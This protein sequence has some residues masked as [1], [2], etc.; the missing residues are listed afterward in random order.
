MQS[1]VPA[2]LSS[3]S[4]LSFAIAQQ[5]KVQQQLKQ[6]IN[7]YETILLNAPLGY[8]QVDDENRLMWCNYQA[9]HLLGIDEG[10][11]KPRLLLE[12]VRSYELDELVETTR[13]KGKLCCTDWTFYYVSPDPS[14]LSEQRTCA[15]R[16]YGFPLPDNQVGIFLENRQEAVTLIQRCDRWASDLAHELKTPLTSIRLVAETL[17]SRLDPPLKTWVDRLISETIRLSN[18]VQDLLDLSR[19]QRD[20]FN[21]LRLQTIDL[22]ELVFA[23]WESLEPLA[24]KQ[25]L[26]LDYQGPDE[27]VLELDKARI[28]RL[29]VNL[30]DNAIKHSPA[31]HPIQV[32]ISLKLPDGETEYTKEEQVCLEVIDYGSGFSERDL[33]HVFDRFYRADPS[34]TRHLDGHSPPADRRFDFP[35]VPRVVRVAS[36]SIGE[37]SADFAQLGGSGLGLAIVQQIVEAHRGSVKAA[38]HPKTGGAWLQVYLPYHP[39]LPLSE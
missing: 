28:H 33:P 11:S 29:L 24:R 15:L 12:L 5:Q 3:T 23:V 8:L 22:I 6:Q 26:Y 21:S 35:Q 25:N 27:L 30:L 32:Q 14:A 31:G 7:T 16:G 4:Q 2:P 36:P 20:A 17:Q 18:L 9:R 34:R 1:D 39:I 19:L 13:S 10:S 37:D 38:N